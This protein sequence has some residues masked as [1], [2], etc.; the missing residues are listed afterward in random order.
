LGV[1]GTKESK[2]THNSSAERSQRGKGI[3]FFQTGE[4]F[5][6]RRGKLSVSP[7]H[8]AG[9][10]VSGGMKVHSKVS[11]RER[12]RVC[13]LKPIEKHQALFETT[14]RFCEKEIFLFL[15]L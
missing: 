4:D 10:K 14:I 5:C 7:I 3:Q 6:T 8:A 2:E 15:R 11:V 1:P 9:Q 12:G 13:R